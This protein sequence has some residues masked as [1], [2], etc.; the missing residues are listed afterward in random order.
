[1]ELRKRV[2]QAVAPHLYPMDMDW[3]E[4]LVIAGDVI[5]TLGLTRE[6]ERVEPRPGSTTKFAP[7]TAER[8]VTLWGRRD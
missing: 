2:A 1:M 5:E 8:Y 7:Y 6:E 4:A 3:E